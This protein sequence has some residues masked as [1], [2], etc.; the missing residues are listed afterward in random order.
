LVWARWDR[1]EEAWADPTTSLLKRSVS[2]HDFY[3]LLKN[4]VLIR[5][6]GAHLQ[7]RRHGSLYFR[8][9]EA[10][11]RLTS[12]PLSSFDTRLDVAAS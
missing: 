3:R 2:G 4:S 11:F 12:R 1:L 8:V 5:F 7:V 6:E 9:G 10:A